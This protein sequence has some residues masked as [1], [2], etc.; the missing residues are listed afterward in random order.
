MAT[1]TARYRHKSYSRISESLPKDTFEVM[2]H[3]TMGMFRKGQLVLDR[4]GSKQTFDAENP[5]HAARVACYKTILYHVNKHRGQVSEDQ[6]DQLMIE[7]D[8]L[9]PTNFRLT[10]LG[11]RG[12]VPAVSLEVTLRNGVYQAR[13]RLWHNDEP[14]KDICNIPPDR[15]PRVFRA[16]SRSAAFEA[17]RHLHMPGQFK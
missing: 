9:S 13:T 4:S 15:H 17:Y 5:A 2:Y 7:Q 14:V 6:R 3:Q 11:E 10:G 1:D 12:D 16:R 8:A